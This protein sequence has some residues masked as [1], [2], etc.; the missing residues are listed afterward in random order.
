MRRNTSADPPD[1]S[2]SSLQINIIHLVWHPLKIYDDDD[3]DDVDNNCHI[4]CTII[5]GHDANAHE[6]KKYIYISL[7]NK[8]Y[9]FSSFK[10]QQCLAI[11]TTKTT[12]PLK[13]FQSTYT[14]T[15]KSTERERDS[16]L[17][18]TKS[19]TI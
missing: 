19:I 13:T 7:Q 4:M 9:Y 6:I 10:L 11:K 15:K 18:Q 14:W 17:L 1:D 2:V 5:H 8:K 12:K 16:L 3:S